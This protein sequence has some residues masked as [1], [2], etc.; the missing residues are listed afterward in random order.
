MRLR[1]DREQDAMRRDSSPLPAPRQPS[2]DAEI[3]Q[4]RRAMNAPETGTVARPVGWAGFEALPSSA[5]SEDRSNA[6]RWSRS[7]GLPTRDRCLPGQQAEDE[8]Q[9]APGREGASTITDDRTA[10]AWASSPRAACAGPGAPVGAAGDTTA[11]ASTAWRPPY[12]PPR[13]VE[14]SGR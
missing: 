11:P 13:R 1:A 5:R 4:A 14:E 9:R 10:R 12:C 3:A 7:P 6:F 8:I 2:A